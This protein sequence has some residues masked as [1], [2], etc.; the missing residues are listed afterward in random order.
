MDGCMDVELCLFVWHDIIMV[1]WNAKLIT[2]KESQ[3]TFKKQTMIVRM[4]RTF[5]LY[6]SATTRRTILF[7][8]T[9]YRV[10]FRNSQRDVPF[11]LHIAKTKPISFT[12][13]EKWGRCDRLWNGDLCVFFPGSVILTNVL[14]LS[15]NFL[16]SLEICTS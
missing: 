16:F 12:R 8:T 9:T 1:T 13:R 2:E 5:P 6:N 15:P 4:R 14:S 11:Y 3:G 10:T 7:T